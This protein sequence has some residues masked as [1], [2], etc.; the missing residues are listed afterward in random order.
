MGSIPLTWFDQTWL[1]EGFVQDT[2]FPGT[3]LFP[4][5]ELDIEITA[6]DVI[7]YGDST[8]VITVEALHSTGPYTF[9][10]SWGNVNTHLDPIDEINVPSGY[11]Y[12]TLTDVYGCQVEGEINVADENPPILSSLYADDVLCHGEATGVLYS[13]VSGG[14]PPYTWNW[15]PSG[16]TEQNPSGVFAGW[17]I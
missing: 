5:P 3:W 14:V 16:R 4:L 9:E 11:Y 1:L 17:H 15:Q 2:V 12:V 7:C 8:G 13:H 6:Q 10:Y